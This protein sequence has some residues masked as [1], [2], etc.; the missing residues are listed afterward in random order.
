[1]A[2]QTICNSNSKGSNTLFLPPQ[3]PDRHGAYIYMQV[4]HPYILIK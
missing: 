1:M 2:A 4:K 3:A